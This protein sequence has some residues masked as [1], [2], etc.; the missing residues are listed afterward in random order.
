MKEDKHRIVH[1]I[2]VLDQCARALDLQLKLKGKCG[3]DLTDQDIPEVAKEI[4]LRTE[5]A[6]ACYEIDACN[7]PHKVLDDAIKHNSYGAE[8]EVCFRKIFNYVRDYFAKHPVSEPELKKLTSVQVADIRRITHSIYKKGIKDLDP[9]EGLVMYPRLVYAGVT[10]RWETF[11]VDPASFVSKAKPSEILVGIVD[12]VDYTELLQMF[13]ATIEG[14]EEVLDVFPN[15]G[16]EDLLK[17]VYIL[18]AGHMREEHKA[19]LTKW[20]LLLI[21]SYHNAPRRRKLSQ[22]ALISVISKAPE[23]YLSVQPASSEDDDD[24]HYIRKAASFILQN[25][26]SGEEAVALI[27]KR[28]KI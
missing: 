5:W 13:S 22:A 1:L 20:L 27:T 9:M 8:Y 25:P 12:G 2:E 26:G 10:S 16:T 14:E 11:F 15:M 28:L 23:L 6:K 19:E 18:L 24:D 21:A 4:Q 7:T 17:T 3:N